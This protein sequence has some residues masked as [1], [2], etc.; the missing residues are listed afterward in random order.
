MLR[1]LSKNGILFVAYLLVFFSS[2][3]FLIHL[4]KKET[5]L[6]L[7]SYHSAFPDHL[8]QFFTIFGD[9]LFMFIVGLLLF[10][11]Q[12]KSG[13]I[14]VSSFIASSLI[15][16]L[17][18][19]FVFMDCKRPVAWFHDLGIEIYRI[20]GIEYHSAFSFP[21]GH[22]T[23]AFALFFGLAFFVK[24][25]GIKFLFLLMAILTGFSRIYVNQHFL[26]DVLAGSV[27]GITS[28]LVMETIFEKS[29][30][31]WMNN[32]IISLIRKKNAHTQK[33]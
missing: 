2:F 7:T 6:L 25:K 31:K 15:V 5:H 20:G 24:N 27:L 26:G 1:I 16:Q 30:A 18:K 10:F 14:I 28:A 33:I 17:L 19:R 9:G 12:I 4:G 21:S 8:M 13:L 3:F 32:N 22:T 11:R 29:K 23:T